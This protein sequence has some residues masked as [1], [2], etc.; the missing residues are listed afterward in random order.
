MKISAIIAGA[1]FM[2]ASLQAFSWG[3]SGSKDIKDINAVRSVV[4]LSKEQVIARLGTPRDASDISFTYWAI[5]PYTNKETICAVWFQNE[6]G[7]AKDVT[8]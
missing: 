1:L 7:T 8:C 3:L 4:G 5:E 6:D 2:G